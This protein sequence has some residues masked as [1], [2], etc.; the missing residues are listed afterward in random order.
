MCFLHMRKMQG[1]VVIVTITETS[2]KASSDKSKMCG[3]FLHIQ[4][5]VKAYTL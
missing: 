3:N 2:S 5:R 4:K 1:M